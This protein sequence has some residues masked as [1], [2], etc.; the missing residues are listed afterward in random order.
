VAGGAIALGPVAMLVLGFGGWLVL[1]A[2]LVAALLIAVGL[3]SP[4]DGALQE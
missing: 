1:I 4:G 2:V 3:R